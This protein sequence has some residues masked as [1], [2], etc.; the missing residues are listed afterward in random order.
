MVRPMGASASS[1]QV[2]FPG[3]TFSFLHCIAWLFV[4]KHMFVYCTMP[5][6]ILF[7]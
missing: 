3:R 2:S 5:A 4:W 6:S 1:G 7:S